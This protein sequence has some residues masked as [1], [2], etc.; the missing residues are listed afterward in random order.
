MITKGQVVH[1]RPEWQDAGDG[2][3]IRIAVENED[4]GRVR[5]VALCG[6]T[7]NPTEVIR[8]DMLEESRG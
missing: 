4:G 7:I 8:V 3:F 5:I 2:Q 6:L 1:I